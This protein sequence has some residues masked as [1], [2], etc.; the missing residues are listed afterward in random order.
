ME[1]KLLMKM[2]HLS[3]QL[4]EYVQRTTDIK[5]QEANDFKPISNKE[6]LDALEDQLKNPTMVSTLKNKLAV[7]CG[8]GKGRGGNNAYTLVDVMFT[9]EFMTICSW[10]GGSKKLTSKICFKIYTRTFN[11]FFDLVHESDKTYTKIECE[12]FF[13]NVMRHAETRNK[14]KLLRASSSKSRPKRSMPKNNITDRQVLQEIQQNEQSL[15]PNS[16][17]IKVNNDLDMQVVEELC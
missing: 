13:K 6:E 3:T 2:T 15:D 4:D 12:N 17:N 8:N 1:S 7:V 16:H 11:L 5:I 14:I 9:R 10:A